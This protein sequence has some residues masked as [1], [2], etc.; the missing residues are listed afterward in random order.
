MTGFNR[1][2][3]TGYNADGTPIYSKDDAAG[4][5][6]GG[7]VGTSGSDMT[8]LNMAGDGRASPDGPTYAPQHLHGFAQN[9]ESARLLWNDA[10]NKNQMTPAQAGQVA[11]ADADA[12]ATRKRQLDLLNSLQ[13]NAQGGGPSVAAAMGREQ[14]DAGIKQAMAAR[15]RAGL[16]VGAASHAATAL[17]TAAGRAGEQQ[18]AWGALQNAAFGVRAGDMSSDIEKARMKQQIDLA[19]AGFTQQGTLANQNAGLASVANRLDASKM[20]GNLANDAV[21]ANTNYRGYEQEK[22]QNYVKRKTAEN[23]KKMR[24]IGT[25]VGVVSKIFGMASDE[26][27]K[28][29]IEPGDSRLKDLLD[30]I[31]VHEYSYKDTNRE[32][33]AP[34]RHV[35][36]MA[37][38]LEKTELGKD[39]VS[40]S[41]EGHKMVNYGRLLGVMLSGEAYLHKRV[42][43][44]EAKVK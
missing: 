16:G 38:E 42:K 43:A 4:G 9:A 35:S 12:M 11:W 2:T 3:I 6:T 28:T 8:G 37:Q 26:R 30:T 13:T 10:Q 44:L 7:T 27:V 20:Y 24:E 29:D 22:Y 31:G 34:G 15:G 39:A 21:S 23:D 32:G 14:M 1:G 17:N 19:N 18:Q 33:T 36:P 25:G 41:K 5:T 40:E